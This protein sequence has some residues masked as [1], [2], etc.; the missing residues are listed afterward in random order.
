MN[1]AEVLISIQHFY[2]TIIPKAHYSPHWKEEDI[3]T[4]FLWAEFCEQIYNKFSDNSSIVKELDNQIHLASNQSYCF[5]NLKQSNSLLCQVTIFHVFYSK[6]DSEIISGIQN[7]ALNWIL[8]KLLNEQNS[9]LVHF[10]WQ[11][12]PLK[13][14]RIAVKYS[15]FGNYYIDFLTKCA[16]SLS[17]DCENGNKSWK[18]SSVSTEVSLEYKQILDH[19]QAVLSIQD[20]LCK[21][22]Q[23][24]LTTL[25]NQET[26]PSIW[27][28][29]RSLIQF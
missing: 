20:E 14:R 21:A 2:G 3:S 13:L 11:Q 10:V 27:Q 5:K 1:S 29:I 23:D 26:E 8:L 4:A 12:P 19:F 17:L 6:S 24:H 28:D 15:S 16:S 18:K 9:H 22:T 7:F 25:L